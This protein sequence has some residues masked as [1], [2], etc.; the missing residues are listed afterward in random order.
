MSVA[1][2][3]K[4][5]HAFQRQMTPQG[6]STTPICPHRMGHAVLCAATE[7]AGMETPQWGVRGEGLSQEDISKRTCW[8]V[9]VVEFT[10]VKSLQ[11]KCCWEEEGILYR[12]RNLWVFL[13]AARPLL[14]RSGARAFRHGHLSHLSPGPGL[15]AHFP[16][17]RGR[18]LIPL[19]CASTGPAPA[20]RPCVQAGVHAVCSARS[21]RSVILLPPPRSCVCCQPPVC[22]RSAQ[23]FLQYLPVTLSASDSLSVCEA[24]P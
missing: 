20:P 23:A 15:G 22:A 14:S 13:L 21:G 10:G 16:R 9:G 18:W 2:V 6:G 3:E 7:A 11:R 8:P 12:C 1:E 5:S 4:S 24:G 17:V 19:S